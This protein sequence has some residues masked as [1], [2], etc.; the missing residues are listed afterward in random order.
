MSSYT[1]L[2]GSKK[3]QHDDCYDQFLQAIETKTKPVEIDPKD[4][5]KFSYKLTARDTKCLSMWQPWASLVIWGFKRFEGRAWDSTFRGPLWI[6]A[7]S[8]V[9]SD[10]EV[11]QVEEQY[12]NLY[13]DVPNMPPFPD[14]YPTGCL[15]GVV[16]LQDVTTNDLYKEH[17]PKRYTKE[18]NS[19]Y[20]FVCR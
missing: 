11:R 13:R 2:L 8:K 18:S 17:V 15:L 4:Y 12:R 9:P 20:L 16:D 5:D 6:Q 3:V 19:E 10:E 1:K 14:R 7:G